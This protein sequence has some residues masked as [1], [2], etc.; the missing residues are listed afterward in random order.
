MSSDF[1]NWSGRAQHP[2]TSVPGETV[3]EHRIRVGLQQSDR[4][5][6]RERECQEQRSP[7]LT[8]VQRLRL[9]ERLHQ[10]RIPAVLQGT[11]ASVIAGDT[12]LSVQQVHEAQLERAVP[13]AA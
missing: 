2:F 11:L 4:I 9:W 7:N 1:D 3:A 8:A 13:P 5:E 10:L 12:G 6:R